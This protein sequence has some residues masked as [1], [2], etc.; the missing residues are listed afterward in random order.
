MGTVRRE[1]KEPTEKFRAEMIEKDVTLAHEKRL[2]AV[3]CLEL[4]KEL[5]SCERKKA[6]SVQHVVAALVEGSVASSTA[7]AKLQGEL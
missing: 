6:E 2:A 1:W 5:E 7:L 4:R 3:T